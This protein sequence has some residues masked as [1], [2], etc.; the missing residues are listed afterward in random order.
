MKKYL[1]P[2]LLLIAIGCSK[3]HLPGT[4]GSASATVKKGPWPKTLTVD[5][6]AAKKAVDGRLYF[7]LDGKRY[8][9]NYNDGKYY[10]FDQSMYGNPA[11][12]PHKRP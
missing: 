8:W 3:K 11:F 4:A 7:D 10:L 9:K 5:D 1:V 6:R 2:L 12:N